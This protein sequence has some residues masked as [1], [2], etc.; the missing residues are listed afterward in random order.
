VREDRY[1]NKSPRMEADL[2]YHFFCCN[3]RAG[4]QHS[5]E[6][7]ES[8]RMDLALKLET[9]GDSKLDRWLVVPSKIHGHISGLHSRYSR[10]HSPGRRRVDQTIQIK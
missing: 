3:I 6:D 4:G 1:E 10:R 8:S 9:T 5:S 7:S 2:A